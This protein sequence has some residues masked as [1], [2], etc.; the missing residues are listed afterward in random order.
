MVVINKGKIWQEL[1]RLRDL[2]SHHRR[3][4]TILSTSGANGEKDTAGARILLNPK[5]K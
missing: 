2:E 5:I 3:I 4:Y 1:D